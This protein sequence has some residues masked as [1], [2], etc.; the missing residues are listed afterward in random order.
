MNR[1]LFILDAR[2]VWHEPLAQA[3]RSRG[4]DARRV[5][6][7]AEVDGPGYGFIRP[8]AE[9]VALKQHRLDG[10]EMAQRL[11][12]VQ[13][14]PQIQLYEDKT[15]QWRRWGRWMPDTWLYTDLDDALHFLAHAEYPL[16]SKAN[17]GASSVNV[18]ILKDRRQAEAHA[19]AVFGAGIKVLHC[20]DN[21]SSMQQGY[22]LLQR[23]IPHDITYRVNVIGRQ[24]AI[25]ERFNYPDRPVAQTGNVR[26][27]MQLTALH[28]SLL[29]YANA[30]SKEAGTRW[31][32]LDILHSPDGWRLL[33]TSLA[34]PWPSPGECMSAPF[35]PGPR[36]WAGMF[37]L[38]MDE[39]E[40]GW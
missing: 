36:R 13:D 37:D 6:S 20:A 5:F 31:V 10:A 4:W 23:F 7:A 33:E 25:F 12:L 27:V 35:F 9:P 24:R 26:P 8:H 11:V 14:Q 28:E 38:L 18:R 3:A 32:A 21:A 2:S 30:F 16:V 34:W 1:N 15:G 22:L 17:E 40:A 39:L 19:E 29:E